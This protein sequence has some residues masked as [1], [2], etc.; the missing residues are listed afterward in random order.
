MDGDFTM[1]LPEHPAVFAYV[2]NLKGTELLVAVNLSTDP[3]TVEIADAPGD[4]V[5]WNKACVVL[6]NQ[7][8]D[9]TVSRA[10]VWISPGAGSRCARGRR[11]C[12]G[13][14]DHLRHWRGQQEDDRV[15]IDV[16]KARG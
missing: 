15:A 9:D 5:G 2:R 12:S 13:P 16:V 4:A 6:T 7:L 14:A 3:Q 11:W 1:L 10:P 8:G